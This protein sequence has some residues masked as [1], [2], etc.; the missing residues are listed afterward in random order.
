MNSER[1]QF[2]RYLSTDGKLFAISMDSSIRANIKDISRG[3]L[4]FK[5]F[6]LADDKA[7]LKKIDLMLE[8]RNRNYLSAINCKVI[9][10]INDLEENGTFSGSQTRICGLKFVKLTPEQERKLLDIIGCVCDK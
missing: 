8:D 2:V 6:P 5:Y 10:D 7:D 9:Y 4:K 3:G 1:R